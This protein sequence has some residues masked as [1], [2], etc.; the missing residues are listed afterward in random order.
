LQEKKIPAAI[1]I[2]NDE[3]FKKL[4]KLKGKKVLLDTENKGIVLL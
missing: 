2:V 1:M 4:E 3:N